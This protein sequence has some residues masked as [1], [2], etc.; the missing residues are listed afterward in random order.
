MAD[1]QRPIIIKK[2]KKGGHGH[3]G[4]AWKVAYADFVTAM[5]AFFLLLWLLSSADE[6][7]LEGIAEYFTPTIGVRDS[8]GIGF[9]GGTTT[10]TEGV[11]KD[12]AAPPGIVQGQVPQGPISEEPKDTMIEA[13]K[14]AKLFEKAEEAIKKAFESDPTL[15]EMADNIIVEQSPEGLKLEVMDSDK[16]PMFDPGSARLTQFGRKILGRMTKIIEELPNFISLTG[17]TDASPGSRADYTN[18]E[19]SADRANAA[20]RYMLTAGLDP[21]RPRKVV[22]KAAT[23]LLLPNDPKSP[24]N[25]RITLIL[26]RGSYMQVDPSDVPITRDL[27]SVPS[28]NKTQAQKLRE[29]RKKEKR[30]KFKDKQKDIRDKQSVTPGQAP[31]PI[32]PGIQ[33]SPVDGLSQPIGDDAATPA[34]EGPQTGEDMSSKVKDSKTE[35][36][37]EVDER[38]DSDFDEFTQ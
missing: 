7:T 3:H 14:D 18:W 34:P 13:E 11:K 15:R 33:Q 17:H 4:G 10:A 23:D 9:Q 22:G 26:L 35:P 2:I 5:M 1:D 32:A 6:A 19:L 37:K 24:R 28:G 20:R 38:P 29:K 27:L 16:F 8:M 31:V 36:P 12:D 30:D 25:R 21:D